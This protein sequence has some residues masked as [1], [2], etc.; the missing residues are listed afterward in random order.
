MRLSNELLDV[1]YI[2]VRFGSVFDPRGSVRF[3]L[4]FHKLSSVSV[5]FGFKDFSFGSV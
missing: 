2:S 5:R 3:G 1:L 4:A